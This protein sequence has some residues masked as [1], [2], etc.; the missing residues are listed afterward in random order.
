MIK[1]IL[2]AGAFTACAVSAQAQVSYFGYGTIGYNEFSEE[3]IAGEIG[4][5]YGDYSLTLGNTSAA[6][7]LV[8]TFDGMVYEF[9]DQRASRYREPIVVRADATFGASHIAISY[10]TELN[11]E[12]NDGLA[13]GFSTSFSGI[14]FSAGYQDNGIFV[15]CCGTENT[16]SVYGASV[17]FDLYGVD[18]TIAYIFGDHANFNESYESLGVNMAYAFNQIMVEGYVVAGNSQD[19]NPI[20]HFDDISYGVSA[21]YDYGSG[22]VRGFFAS[23]NKEDPQN[24]GVDVSYTGFSSIALYAG[25]SDPYGAYAGVVYDGLGNGIELG[26]SYSEYDAVAALDGNY[27]F[28]GASVWLT[29]EF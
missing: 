27:F 26:L 8:D 28:D 2:M 5:A 18:T 3:Y 25:Y 9:Y 23:E 13:V 7:S 11:D 16:G 1:K 19:N 15:G 12:G 22:E 10:E 29:A 6:T 14:D 17:G 20:P 24:L 4:I 21:S